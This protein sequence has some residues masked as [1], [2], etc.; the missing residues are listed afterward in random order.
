MYQS[1]IE[2]STVVLRWD[3]LLGGMEGLGAERERERRR[4]RKRRYQDI[5]YVFIKSAVLLIKR[6]EKE[7]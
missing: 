5:N 2:H 6:L 7:M 4:R 1:F 3:T